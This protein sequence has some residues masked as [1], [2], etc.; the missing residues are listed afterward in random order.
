MRNIIDRGEWTRHTLDASPLKFGAYAD[1]WLKGRTLKPTTR[2]H[3][4]NILDRFLIPAFGD[5]VLKAIAPADVRAWH[6]TQNVDRPTMRAHTY[7]LLR[8]ILNTAYQDDLITANPCRVPG[9]GS[10]KTVKPIRPATLAELETITNAMPERLRAM[11]LIGAWGALRFGEI[12]ELRRGDLDLEAGLVRVRRGVTHVKG[13]YII[14]TPKSAAGVRDVNIPPHLIPMLEAH[15]RDHTGKGAQALLFPAADG[16]NYS[17]SAM[18]Y[19]WRRARVVAGR[20]DLR[21]HDL[22]HTG[23]VLAASTGATLAE[24]MARLGHSSTSAAMRYQ[25][26]A[27]NRDRSIADMLSALVQ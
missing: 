15:L 20:P 12:T 17:A 11:V 2:N 26:A 1:Q 23:A 13:E 14:G 3:Y 9:G 4:R 6:D 22:R 25:H 18:D 21:F 27:T 7:A 16:R 5:D 19:H 8:T 24:L 10:S